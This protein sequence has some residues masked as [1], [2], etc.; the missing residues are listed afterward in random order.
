[1]RIQ[2]RIGMSIAA[3]L[4][5]AAVGGCGAEN[6]QSAPELVDLSQARTQVEAFGRVSAGEE[7]N[8]ALEFPA[9]VAG[10]MVA[11]GRT[12]SAGQPVLGLDTADF[13]AEIEGLRQELRVARL[14]VT[15]AAAEL[16]QTARQ[17][18]HDIAYAESELQQSQADLA[19]REDL[20]VNGMFSRDDMIR[21][22]REAAAR[23]KTLQDLQF[24]LEQ[25][26]D[27]LHVRILQ[28][29][30]E[31]LN[32]RIERLEAGKNKPYLDG[33][34]IVSPFEQ[35]AVIDM[36]LTPGDMIE[37][38]R[39]IL[40]FINL[41]SLQVNADVLEEFIHDVQPDAPVTM[42]PIADRSR[43]YHGRIRSIGTAAFVRNNETVVP[44]E[45]SIDDADAFLR[46]NFNMDLYIDI[47]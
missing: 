36:N 6:D 38:G 20:H 8:V 46:H 47:P 2:A 14:E 41:E 43:E 35:A 24:Q 15:A 37:A 4:L 45:V 18:V 12:V 11:N 22:R 7:L 21:F 28:E 10:V 34:A 29:R 5:A 33:G 9:R 13:D 3:V 16:D 40:R 17:L 31:A 1:M 27:S 32:T 26:Q 42:I 44:V 25:R 19:A 23:E 30:A 39:S